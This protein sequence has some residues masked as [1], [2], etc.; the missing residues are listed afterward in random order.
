VAVEGNHVY[1]HLIYTTGDA[2]GQNMVTIATQAVCAYILQHCPLQPRYWFVEA[3]FSGDKKA[4]AQ[5]MVNGRGKRV[6]AEVYLPPELVRT[7]L[8]TT[9]QRMVEFLRMAEVGAMLSGTLGVQG[10]YAN[11][12]AALFIA[13]G[14]DAACVAESATGITRLELTDDGSLYVAITLP[15]LVVGTV[16]GG[17]SLPTQQACLDILRLAGPGHAQAFAEVCAGLCLAGEISLIAALSAGHFTRAH[18]RLARER[19]AP[20]LE[21]EHG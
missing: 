1:L 14:Q 13:C 7:R 6:S 8:H 5:A 4:S 10:H 12:L 15:N 19:V 2:A 17:T 18:Q 20:G 11:G 21:V 9:P 16:G 3:N